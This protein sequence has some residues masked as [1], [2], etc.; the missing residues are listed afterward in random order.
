MNTTMDCKSVRR[1]E[2]SERQWES[3]R[4][5]QVGVAVAVA[6]IDTCIVVGTQWPTTPTGPTRHHMH[7]VDRRLRVGGRYAFHSST[8]SVE[9]YTECVTLGDE[10]LTGDGLWMANW[11]VTKQD[12]RIGSVS[13]SQQAGAIELKETV[14]VRSG[15]PI[16]FADSLPESSRC[17]Y[18]GHVRPERAANCGW[19]E[20]V[21][22]LQKRGNG[23]WQ[24][25]LQQLRGEPRS[26]KQGAQGW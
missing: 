14:C 16:V 8:C 10:L 18:S 5:V 24:I 6:G 3:P 11:P 23:L 4:E 17:C 19:L 13:A 22:T 2:R 12:G 15:V 9:I 1:D 25:L 20:R 26:G 7:V 21:Q